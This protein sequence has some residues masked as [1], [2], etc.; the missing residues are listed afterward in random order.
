MRWI[1][2][3]ADRRRAQSP[4]PGDDRRFA[5]LHAPFAGVAPD[6]D[7]PP[8]EQDAFCSEEEQ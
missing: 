2:E 7:D 3:G 1:F 5:P 6:A 4:F 8:T